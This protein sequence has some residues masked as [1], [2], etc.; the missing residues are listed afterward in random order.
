MKE[1][2]LIIGAGMYSVVAKEIAQS[3]GKFEKIGFVDDRAKTAADGT[4]VLGTTD[5]IPEI[6]K[7]YGNFIVAIGNPEVRLSLIERLDSPSCRVT[8][9]V[10]P[11]AYVAPS[12]KVEKGC[13]I[14]PMAVIH[15]FCEI[16]KGCIVSAGA[17]INHASVCGEGVHVDCNAT[18]EG[19]ATVPS[20]TKVYC[21]EIFKKI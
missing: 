11:M 17:V 7:E 6:S 18:V 21:G 3:M 15:S 8:S 19:Y 5:E 9:L 12:A 2:L 13:I 14:E 10:S 1:N 4:P 16:S 20:K